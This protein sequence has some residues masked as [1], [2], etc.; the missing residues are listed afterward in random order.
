M[1]GGKEENRSLVVWY[2][3]S[4]SN[5]G[6]VYLDVYFHQDSWYEEVWE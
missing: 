5:I 6:N 4:I 2:I 1:C 3:G